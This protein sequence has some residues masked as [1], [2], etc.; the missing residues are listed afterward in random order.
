MR[1]K[2]H[3]GGHHE[4]HHWLENEQQRVSLVFG[5]FRKKA[6]I[7][8]K[9]ELES[10]SSSTYTVVVLAMVGCRCICFDTINDFLLD[11]ASGAAGV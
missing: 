11:V 5:C 7:V 9:H 10:Q 2:V 8:Q 6:S 1:K 3:T 4:D